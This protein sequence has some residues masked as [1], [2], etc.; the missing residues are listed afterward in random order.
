M[1][2]TRGQPPVRGV[3]GNGNEALRFVAPLPESCMG[4]KAIGG[5][6]T[7]CFLADLWELGRVLRLAAWP[8]ERPQ[9]EEQPDKRGYS[10]PLTARREIY[11]Q[12]RLSQDC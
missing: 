2:A 3:D 8:L 12:L 9:L 1:M 4:F 6:L 5:V 11:K 10:R 7:A